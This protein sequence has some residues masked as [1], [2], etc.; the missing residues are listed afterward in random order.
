MS[1]H[2]HLPV[3]YPGGKFKLMPRLEPLFPPHRVYV[4]LFGGTGGDILGRERPAG[5]TEVYN[6]LSGAASNYINTMRD[7]TAKQK[8]IDTIRSTHGRS[9]LLC[10]LAV[11]TLAAKEQKYLV[12]RQLSARLCN[13]WVEHAEAPDVPDVEWTAA[14]VYVAV[15]SYH[16]VEPGVHGRGGFA[17]DFR[18]STKHRWDRIPD[19]LEWINER[20]SNVDICTLDYREAIERCKDKDDVFYYADPPYPWAVRRRNKIYRHEFA[21]A[22]QIEFLRQMNALKHAK[23]MIS[24]YIKGGLETVNDLYLRELAGWRCKDDFRTRSPVSDK[25]TNKRAPR[26][27]VVWMNYGPDGKR[28][29]DKRKETTISVPKVQKSLTTEMTKKKEEIEPDEEMTTFAE[30]RKLRDQ[31][32]AGHYRLLILLG[33]PGR[34]KSWE[35]EQWCYAHPDKCWYIRGHENPKAFY[36]GCYEHQH[37][38]IV[39]DDVEVLWRKQEGRVHIRALSEHTP[40]RTMQRDIDREMKRRG[41][42]KQFTTTS[43]ICLICNKLKMADHDEWEAV[44]DRGHVVLFKPNNEEI[45]RNAARWFWD[46]EIFTWVGERLCHCG[47]RKPFGARIYTTLWGWKKGGQQWQRK[48]EKLLDK[49]F[50]VFLKAMKQNSKPAD[51][52]SAFIKAT[53]RDERTY[54]HWQERY[55]ESWP[56][57]KGLKCHGKEP[58]TLDREKLRH[59]AEEER[60]KQREVVVD[61]DGVEDSDDEVPN[62]KLKRPQPNGMKRKAGPKKKAKPRSKKAN[63]KKSKRNNDR[64]SA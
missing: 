51:R 20:L 22:D 39:L 33:V 26:N 35:F 52:V 31:F 11:K 13:I 25:A 63:G 44:A 29:D 36:S 37:Y 8:L 27:E 42:P 53:G 7:P 23:A 15:T 47:F 45:H 17:F 38:D 16:A 41:I 10:R 50:A 28:L 21:E 49:D 6:D 1:N 60:R 4:S 32:F 19:Y 5:V 14:Y 64:D 55:K 40:L 18:P 56:Q 54:Y 62:L 48:A 46:Q 30:L 58:V 43:N 61:T 57:A 34:S 3:S 9:Q 24:S 2:R 59:E 12:K